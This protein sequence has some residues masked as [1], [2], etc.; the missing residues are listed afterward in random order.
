MIIPIFIR[1]SPKGRCRGKQLNLGALL[2]R[3][4][5]RPLLFALAFDNGFA[6]REAAFKSLNGSNSATIDLYSSSWRS[7]M[8][9]NVTL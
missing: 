2:R 9:W 4:Q 5:E 1:W 8:D 7:E 3:R 6:D